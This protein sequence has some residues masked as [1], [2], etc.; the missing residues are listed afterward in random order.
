[1]DPRTS[2]DLIPWKIQSAG[3]LSWAMKK[4]E[5]SIKISRAK[6]RFLFNAL[7]EFGQRYIKQEIN[8]IMPRRV[9]E[10]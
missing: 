3:D 7:Y 5:D 10:Y 6:G 9:N 4:Y 2:N 1:M 8:F